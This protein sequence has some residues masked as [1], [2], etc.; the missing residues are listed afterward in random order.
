MLQCLL[1]DK[2]VSQSARQQ[3][4][5]VG[6]IFKTYWLVTYR[7]ELLII[8]QHAA[9]EKVKYEELIKNLSEKVET[10][11]EQIKNL[12]SENLNLKYRFVF[13]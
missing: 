10:Q 9:H 2:I 7:E 6:Q 8:D 13:L 4:H 3:Y 5:I 12:K 1:E 11:E